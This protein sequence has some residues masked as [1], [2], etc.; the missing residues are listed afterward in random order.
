[1]KALTITLLLALAVPAQA[2]PIHYYE[3]EHSVVGGPVTLTG[4]GYVRLRI[5]L[6]PG[7]E[8]QA[9][10]LQVVVHNSQGARLSGTTTLIVIDPSF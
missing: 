9:L 6:P 1:M 2:Q 8:G 10:Y 7:V 5:H 3:Y 4:P